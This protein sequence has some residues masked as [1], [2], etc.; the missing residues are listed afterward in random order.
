MDG[1]LLCIFINY[2]DALPVN[3]DLSHMQFLKCIVLMLVDAL[4]ISPLLIEMCH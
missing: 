4:N 3:I 1:V 2:N